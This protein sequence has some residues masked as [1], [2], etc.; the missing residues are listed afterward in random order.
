MANIAIILEEQRF[1]RSREGLSFVTVRNQKVF[2]FR[3]KCHSFIELE[4][5]RVLPVN[6]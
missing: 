3:K 1:L 4:N 6:W 2:P 5:F